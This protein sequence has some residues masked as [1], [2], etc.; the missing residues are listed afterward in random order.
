MLLWRLSEECR[1]RDTAADGVI[2]KLP[3]REAAQ[4]RVCN[5]LYVCK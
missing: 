3:A 1:I 5:R 4:Q 2:Y